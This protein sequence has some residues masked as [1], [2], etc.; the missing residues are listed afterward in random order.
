MR[1]GPIMAAAD[2]FE[3]VVK[4]K[5]G[6]AAKPHGTIDPVVIGAQIVSALQTIISR[7]TNPVDPAV[8]SITNFHAG[9]G[10]FNVIAEEAKLSGTIRSF[11]PEVREML[12]RRVVEVASGIAGTYGASVTCHYAEGYDPTINTPEA[13][14]FC[15]GV[16]RKVVGEH[17]VDTDMDPSMGAE[18]FGAMLMQK[19]G[20]YIIMGQ[21]EPD[22]PESNHN[23][24]LHTPQYD[25]NDEIIPVGVEY[26]ATLVEEALALEKG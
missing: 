14:E 7:G 17:N 12:K 6:H 9:T 10:A 19:P 21:G 25:F 15:A 26:W 13:T 23:R 20:C 5:G 24:G 18:D 16:A 4:G 3:M 11:D 2:R 1:T 22:D 8:I